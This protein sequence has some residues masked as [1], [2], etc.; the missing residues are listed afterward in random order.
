MASVSNGN[1]KWVMWLGGLLFTILFTGFT[2]LTNNVIANDKD[3]RKRDEKIA[4]CMTTSIIEQKMVNQEILIALKEMQ[5]DLKYI[6]RATP[7]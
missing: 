5:T 4:D 7:N 2:T 6:K 3:S 1:G